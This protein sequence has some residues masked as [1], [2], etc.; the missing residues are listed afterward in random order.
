MKDYEILKT[1]LDNDFT[2]IINDNET[3]ETLKEMFHYVLDGG[4]RLRPILFYCILN[5]SNHTN[6]HRQYISEYAL[7]LELL[8]TMS[9]ILDDLPCMDND[10]LRRGKDS[11]HIKYG[12]KQALIFSSYVFYF[13]IRILKK[14]I[15]LEKN[16]EEFQLFRKLSKTLYENLGMLGACGGQ[17]LDLCPIIPNINKKEFIDTY[18]TKEGMQEL[19]NLKTTT[20]FKLGF[21]FGFYLGNFDLDINKIDSMAYNFGLAFQIYDDFDDLNQDTIRKSEGHFTPNYVLSYG[22]NDAFYVFNKSI[23]EFKNDFDKCFNENKII[24]DIIYKLRNT[25]NNNYN[26]LNNN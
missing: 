22:K 12:E 4:K 6:H 25:V 24:N 3:D 2:R 15:F 26:N 9:L 1:Q 21:I 10:N 20:I 14:Y 7:C 16:K 8:H 19:L 13:C 11:F 23:N 18:S 17:F 5:S